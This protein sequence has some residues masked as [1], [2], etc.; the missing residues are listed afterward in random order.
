MTSREHN[1][2]ARLFRIIVDQWLACCTY[3]AARL[4]IADLLAGG[5]LPVEALAAAS[6][7]H[8]QSLYRVLRALA[9]EGIF[10]ETTPGIF[11]LTPD[12]TALQS[13]TPGTMKALPY[14]VGIL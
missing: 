13:N 10:E 8:A 2:S 6:G 11:A 14:S 1:P 9:S 3:V 12:A 7:S 5:P 4:N